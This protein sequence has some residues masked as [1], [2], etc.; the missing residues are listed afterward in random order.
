VP[1]DVRAAF[2]AR[3]GEGLWPL[4]Q[5]RDPTMAARLAPTDTQRILRALEV[6]TATGRSLAEWQSMPGAPV[7]D[8]L[9]TIRLTVWRERADLQAR[10]DARFDAMLAEGALTE[11]A[12]LSA[13]ALPRD[14]PALKALGVAP[15]MAHLSGD[16]TI[17]AAAAEAKADTRRYVKRQQT[18]L[19]KFMAGWTAVSGDDADDPVRTAARLF[20]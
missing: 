3:A 20:A 1:A 9:S 14:R 6:V 4:L 13:L 17:E 18:W 11:V 16:L 5:E 10:C 12:A 19:R 2:R 15:L 7:F 8:A